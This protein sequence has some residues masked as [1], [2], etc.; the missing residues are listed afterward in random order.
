MSSSRCLS[1]SIAAL[2]VASSLSG[3]VAL[4]QEPPTSGEGQNA[5]QA[6][7]E[8]VVTGTS[9]RGVA[10]IGSNLVTVGVEELEKTQAINLSTLVNT[11]PA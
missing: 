10:P 8:I 9:I 2:T 7:E 3:R 4:A 1:A 5:A 11:I 6:L